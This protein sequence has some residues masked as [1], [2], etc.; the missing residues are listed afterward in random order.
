MSKKTRNTCL[1]PIK[2]LNS[3]Y[4][5]YQ[6]KEEVHLINERENKIGMHVNNKKLLLNVFES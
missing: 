1:N 6:L 4:D 3:L 5:Y 2:W